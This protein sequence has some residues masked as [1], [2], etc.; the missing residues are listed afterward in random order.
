[1]LKASN[2]LS[3]IFYNEQLPIGEYCF[4]CGTTGKIYID[5]FSFYIRVVDKTV[6]G[7][8][9]SINWGCKNCLAKL[10]EKQIE[11]DRNRLIVSQEN[12]IYINKI[13][14]LSKRKLFYAFQ[15][16]KKSNYYNK[17]MDFYYSDT[18]KYMLYYIEMHG[19][20]ADFSNFIDTINI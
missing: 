7:Y 15:Q 20:L 6:K 16:F 10:Q 4:Y 17:I 13:N 11:I 1:M 3:P 2:D 9:I 12:L 8:Y 14:K 5:I 19:L 18:K